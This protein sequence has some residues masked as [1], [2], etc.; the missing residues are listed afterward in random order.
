MAAE[1]TVEKFVASATEL[2]KYPI[3]LSKT[4][5]INETERSEG[6]VIA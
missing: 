6:G 3:P 2:G 5:E 4:S 1:E